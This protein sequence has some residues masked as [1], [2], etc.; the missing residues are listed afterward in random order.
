MFKPKPQVILE[1]K[2]YADG[3]LID[4]T[5][6]VIEPG[7]DWARYIILAITISWGFWLMAMGGLFR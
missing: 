2:T 3:V 5:A 4:Q 1:I 7:P 6:K